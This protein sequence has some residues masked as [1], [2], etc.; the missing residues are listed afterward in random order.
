MYG[1]LTDKNICRP[2]KSQALLLPLE[3]IRGNG[4]LNDI[5]HV[6]QT[7]PS[8]KP[9]SIEVLYAE[10]L[11][12]ASLVFPMSYVLYVLVCP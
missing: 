11:Y 9:R 10:L 12:R 6:K 8:T 3:R 1:K 4:M 2:Q 7:H 5:L